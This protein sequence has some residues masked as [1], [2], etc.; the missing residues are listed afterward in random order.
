MKT[1]IWLKGHRF[2]MSYGQAH[3]LGQGHLKVKVNPKSNCK[4]L[5]FYW[6]VGN[7]PSTERHS[8]LRF[9]DGS[10]IVLEGTL[11]FHQGSVRVFNGYEGP[12][13]LP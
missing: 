10:V 5:T 7:G 6:Q 11:G 9:C 12:T 13:M 3:K 8:S 2:H 1:L 4:C